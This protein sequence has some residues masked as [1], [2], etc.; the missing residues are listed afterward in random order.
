MALVRTDASEECWFL[1]E[2]SC[3]KSQKTAFFIIHGVG[4]DTYLRQN[5]FKGAKVSKCTICG[6]YGTML[7]STTLS[8]IQIMLYQMT[9]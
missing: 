6:D 4:N 1:Q 8:I 5:I 7:Y 2:L 3:V 9:G